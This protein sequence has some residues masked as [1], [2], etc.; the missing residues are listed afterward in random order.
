MRL[1]LPAA[2]LAAALALWTATRRVDGSTQSPYPVGRTLRFDAALVRS[3]VWAARPD[4]P[5][6]G[7]DLPVEFA[8]R[9]GDTLVEILKELG[10]EPGE[11]EAVV[12]QVTRHV[13]V[14][15]LRTEDRYAAL[16]DADG[17]LRG[18]SLTIAGKGRV[19]VL[20]QVGKR[21]IPGDLRELRR[22]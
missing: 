16:V 19:E 6:A 12:T 3:A 13:D 8:F 5:L 18:F 14:R 15:R 11:A 1:G 20:R 21:R 2:L 22:H 4:R 9:I 10:L 17:A 7:A